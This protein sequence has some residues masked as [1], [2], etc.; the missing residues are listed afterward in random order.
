MVK[1]A[2]MTPTGT[3]YPWVYVNSWADPAKVLGSSAADAICDPQVRTGRT[4]VIGA[5][6][7]VDW[8]IWIDGRGIVGGGLM[9]NVALSQGREDGRFFA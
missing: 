1:H 3:E 7:I 6:V 5:N 9:N 8:A 4:V 2:L